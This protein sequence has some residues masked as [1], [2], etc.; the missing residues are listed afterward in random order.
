MKDSDTGEKIEAF[1]YDNHTMKNMELYKVKED[2]TLSRRYI[3]HNNND[4]YTF[5][6]TGNMKAR[7]VNGKYEYFISGTFTSSRSDDNNDIKLKGSDNSGEVYYIPV[8]E[9]IGVYE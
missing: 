3:T 6:P 2:G 4:D 7:W 1:E 9:R 5:I 8:K